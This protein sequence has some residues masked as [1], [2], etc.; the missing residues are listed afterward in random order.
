MRRTA[1]LSALL[2]LFAPLVALTAPPPAVAHLDGSSR[3]CPIPVAPGSATLRLI[4][5]GRTGG[6][7][8]QLGRNRA[9]L[10]LYDRIGDALT[11]VVPRF[12]GPRVFVWND[13]IAFAPGG[14]DI[15]TFHRFLAAGPHDRAVVFESMPAVESPFEL[16]L[17]LPGPDGASLAD[18]PILD[19]FLGSNAV[20][21]GLRSTRLRWVRYTAND[22]ADIDLL[23]PVDSRPLP[24]LPEDPAVWEI[25]WAFQATV[26]P[27][28]GAPRTLFNIGRP[29]HDGARRLAL[30]ERLRA[31]A[32]DRTLVLAAGDDIETYSFTAAGVPDKQRPNTWES[33]RRM[34]LTALVPGG[35]EA[36]FGLDQLQR[37]AQAHEVAVLGANVPDAPFAGW[38]L[39]AAGPVQ[40]L[41][42]GLVNPDMRPAD[43]RRGFGERAFGDEAA[44]VDRAVREA[45][46][47]LGRRPDLVIALGLLDPGARYR[48]LRD[49][50]EVDI[51]LADFADHGIH[52]E[53]LTAALATPEQQAARARERH[54]LPVA[55][56][57]STR[58]GLAEVQLV[59]DPDTGRWQVATVESQ[60][61]PVPGDLPADRQMATAVQALRQAVYAPAQARLLP[62]LGPSIAEDP[63]LFARFLASD[64]IKRLSRSW[65]TVPARVTA[66][67]WRTM[68]ANA[69]A[70]RLDAEVVLLPQIPFPWSLDGPITTLEAVANL[71][72]PDRIRAMKLTAADL[73]TLAAA[74]VFARL[75]TAGIT[76]TKDGLTVRGRLVDDR[77]VYRVAFADGLVAEP[78]FATIL[79]RPS[80][81]HFVK[82]GDDWA[83]DEGGEPLALRDLAVEALAA[84]SE[85][86]PTALTAWMHPSGADKRA[87]WVLDLQQLAFEG[88]AY[89]TV[90]A[91]TGV[92]DGYDE[93]RETRVR[94]ANHRL[95]AARGDV[96][97]NREGESVDWVNRLHLEFAKGFYEEAAD[98]ET[99]DDLRLS[100]ELQ[101]PPWTL[102]AIGGVPFANVALA[103]EFTPTEGNPRKQ[104]IEGALGLL[105]KGG[106]VTQAR[107]AALVVHDFSTDVPDP[108]LGALA[109]LGLRVELPSSVWTADGEVRYFIPNI[110]ADDASELGLV[111]KLRTGLDVPLFARLS[112]GIYVDLYAYRGQ[113]PAT[114]DPGA[115][116]ISGLSLKYD[117]RLKLAGVSW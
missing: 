72:V 41:I 17:E 95:V 67:L 42:V 34:K 105:W 21:P 106:I 115:S 90:G 74:P 56:A 64:R 110:G 20:L 86:G 57:G 32:P 65:G 117:H 102:P 99:A 97:L 26:T 30:V 68:V 38:R 43:R 48:L 98:Q 109:A 39:V 116:V 27:T 82:R 54:P 113:I 37:D 7:S 62:D 15:A 2:A 80:A 10:A 88:S 55:P 79:G 93:V 6:I 77:E 59:A 31:E 45:T 52:R 83:S 47:R 63:A 78:A 1:R 23:E 111:A 51:L 35:A 89:V 4:W 66:D 100:T 36:A 13:R 24:A 49:S 108:Q 53:A 8:G 58:L 33:F 76:T 96:F 29:L 46:E 71:N 9:H 81:D 44:A 112:L 22:G 5:F 16:L 75:S 3:V 12:E 40:V 60:A 91:G 28:G 69:V 61:V 94:T 70:E 114:H 104:Q 25:R 85:G 11:E 103:T 107:G 73:R 87:R 50:G 92:D 14:L 101:V 18:T 84:R 19:L